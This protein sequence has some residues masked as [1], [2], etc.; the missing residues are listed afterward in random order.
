M[1]IFSEQ[2]NRK[3]ITEILTYNT[4]ID[5][6]SKKIYLPHG[7]K[8]CSC[9]FTDHFQAECHS[10]SSNYPHLVRIPI[11][12]LFRSQLITMP[13]LS[14]VLGMYRNYT[15]DITRLGSIL[16]RALLNADV[17]LLVGARLN[18]ILHFGHP[19][20]YSPNVKIIQVR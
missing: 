14:L 19:P 3:Y 16:F 12:R 18:W 10:V 17:I 6:I 4:G 8:Y 20:R 9:E 13:K 1:C 11:S 7:L 2:L 5:T 15:Y